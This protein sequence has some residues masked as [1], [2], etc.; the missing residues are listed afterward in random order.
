MP[1]LL[2]LPKTKNQLNWLL[3]IASEQGIPYREYVKPAKHVSPKTAFLKEIA[4]AGKHAKMIAQ[5]QMKGNNAYTLLNE[6]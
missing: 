3:S 5:G 6:L 4:D 2:F 1:E